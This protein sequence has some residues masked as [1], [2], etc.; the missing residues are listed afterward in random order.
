MKSVGRDQSLRSTDRKISIFYDW[1]DRKISVV[2]LMTSLTDGQNISSKR[3]GGGYHYHP[4]PEMQREKQ[5]EDLLLKKKVLLS[6]S[7]QGT[8]FLS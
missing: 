7:G 8:Y 6:F 2:S 3:R 4:P 1:A 5:L